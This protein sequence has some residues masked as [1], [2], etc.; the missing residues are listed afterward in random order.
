MEDT[1]NSAKIEGQPESNQ[2]ER[3]EAS[4]EKVD[5][6]VLNAELEKE[7]AMATQYL[8]NWQR[9]QADFINYKR[10]V[11]Q[12]KSDL[13]KYGSAMLILRLLTILDDMERAFATIPSELGGFTWFQGM[14]LI[15][16]KF[17]V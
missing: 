16:R 5:I 15:Y 3:Q 13:Q 9:A 12:E 1:E 2:T 10:R 14:G 6:E 4:T 17:L 8:S 11:D 7:R